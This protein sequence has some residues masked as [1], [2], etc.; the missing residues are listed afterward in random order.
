MN[1][2]VFR[3]QIIVAPRGSIPEMSEHR[4]SCPQCAAFA[5]H[6]ERL[7]VTLTEAAFVSPPEG[8]ANRILLRRSLVD[9]QPVSAPARRRFLALAASVAAASAGLGAWLQWRR[10]T[11]PL[12]ADIAREL[13]AHLLKAHPP[14]LGAAA[15]LVSETEVAELLARAGFAARTSLGRVENAWPCTFRD[16]PIA[17]LVLPF[18]TGPVT[19]L[20][21]PLALA[22]RAHP[23]AGPQLKGLITPCAHGVLALLAAPDFELSAIAARLSGALVAA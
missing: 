14:G 3:K 15:H 10:A 21:L 9:G 17:H 6:V 20:V 16:Q 1:C 11:E 23:F 19:A 2:L 5:V 12:N 13:V 8:L 18:A 4:T 7:E 22:D